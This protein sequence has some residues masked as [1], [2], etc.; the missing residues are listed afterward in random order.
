MRCIVSLLTV[1]S[2]ASCASGA[3]YAQSPGHAQDTAWDVTAPRG[4]TRSIDFT[5]DEGTWMSLSVSPDGRWIV[6]D[7]LGHI[8]RVS[9]DGGR[10][11]ALTQSSGIAL[12]Y[13]P[14]YSPDGTHI[15]F[16]SDRAG[17]SD[18]WVM[19]ADGSDPRRIGGHPGGRAA[20]P[21]WS[22]DGKTVYVRYPTAGIWAYSVASGQARH[23]A[24]DK[25]DYLCSPSASPDGRHLYFQGY[26]GGS[27]A[28]M[29]PLDANLQIIRLN[30]RRDEA[31]PEILS[32]GHWGEMAPR[33]SPDG[34]YLAFVR[35]IPNGTIRYR[36]H[37]FGPRAALWVRDLATGETRLVA[38]P[39]ETDLAEGWAANQ[40]VSFFP[41]YSWFPD[42][43]S[44]AITRGGKIL[45]VWIED[46]ETREIP[47]EA[48]VLREISEQARGTRRVSDDPLE[49]RFLR[50]IRRSPGGKS[51]LFQAVNR[52]WISK[53]GSPARPLLDAGFDQ[54][55][56]HAAW[57]T[58][59]DQI[60]FT[61]W[62]PAAR[63]HLWIVDAA[64]G[65]PERLSS[66][67]GEYH[68]PVWSRDGR[69]VYVVRN[70]VDPGPGRAVNKNQ[71]YHIVAYD[72]AG[73]SGPR[74][75]T[76]ALNP[77]PRE[78]PTLSVA[79]SGRVYFTNPAADADGNFPAMD[80]VSI[81]PG[82]DDD[83][84]QQ[85][86]MR[87]PH[88][89]M[90]AV[91][92]NEE[93]VAAEVL[94]NVY[95]LPMPS[96]SDRPTITLDQ[97]VSSA[98]PDLRRVSTGGGVYPYWEDRD[99]LAY[100]HTDMLIVHDV[101]GGDSDRIDVPLTL[102]RE[103]PKG[104]IVLRG[105]RIVTLEEQGLVQGDVVI[106]GARIRCIGECE[107]YAPN[108]EINVSGKVIIPG[109][110][111]TH[112][113]AGWYNVF[114]PAR[115]Q[116]RAAYLAYGVTTS[117]I[118]VT[119]SHAVFPLADLIETGGAIGPRVFTAGDKVRDFSN[120]DVWG[121]P[122]PDSRSAV[123]FVQRLED[124]G[125][126]LVITQQHRSDRNRSELQ[127]LVAAARDAGLP[128]TAHG[129][130]G[131]LEVNLSLAMDGYA[132]REHSMAI[133]PQYRDVTRFFGLAGVTHI[134]TITA[135]PRHAA[136]ELIYLE[137][138]LSR[139][140]KLQRFWRTPALLSA[141]VLQP[142]RRP[143]WRY[144]FPLTAE[145]AKDIVE[146]GGYS[147][148]GTEGLNP[149]ISMHW[150]MWLMATAREPLAVLESASVHAARYLGLEQDLGSLAPGKLADLLVLNADP[151]E[152]IENTADIRYVMKGG[153]LY[154]A[155]TLDQIWPEQRPFGPYHWV[156]P[157]M[158]RDD[159][160]PLVQGSRARP[161]DRS[162]E[163]AVTTPSPR[164]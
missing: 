143:A 40:I 1:I 122:I 67:P 107:T 139:D 133:V 103:I 114:T 92:P 71:R 95:L 56:Y 156:E 57:S 59:G 96:P 130:Y 13:D 38:D 37:T 90:A 150:E 145:V 49:L 2:A 53:N 84:S 27:P 42:S 120:R 111:D 108:R 106:E 62:D 73:A 149:G 136:Q 61:T 117:I 32:D 161:A 128:V 151:L 89:G 74:I 47:F 104:T 99:V 91:S 29:E 78:I 88:A 48:R 5:T 109:L 64:G 45:R 34:R 160:R 147:T 15:A 121:T 12:N 148:Y 81:D 50:W 115:S 54:P 14:Q 60:T 31:V 52:L 72:A 51:V 83:G 155:A 138:D 76:P 112:G 44:I 41:R 70:V 140:S 105:A 158:L 94:G 102:P 152:D 142:P 154:D 131:G 82:H 4:E 75:L 43:E 35:R 119:W 85:T 97:L 24:G 127:M 126:S 157:N 98:G 39:V 65:A 28:Y 69:T 3:L 9:S 123:E 124:W 8:Y 19:D 163:S 116:E 6:F 16:V 7:L 23:L 21:E 110:I 93:W 77:S 58:G 159:S 132:A 63:G 80:L 68:N 36:G 10:S 30:L 113:S 162:G 146:H 79:A 22:P 129:I 144:Q 87:I 20:E 86:R 17:K 33:L 55:Q 134:S 18:L 118:P 135:I 100:S 141:E 46:G 101:S 153:V 164:N 125:A 25:E 26:T 11:T 137:R 66:S